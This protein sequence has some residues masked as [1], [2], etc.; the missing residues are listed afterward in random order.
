[1]CRPNFGL[2]HLK[3]AQIKQLGFYMVACSICMML[4]LSKKEE[5]VRVH[6]DRVA[7]LI[8]KNGKT[9]KW[10]ENLTQCKLRIDSKSGEITLIEGKNSKN[11]YNALNIIRA[12]GR[13]FSPENAIVLLD[14][15][16]LLD[17]LDLQDFLGKKQID[18]KKA[19]VIGTKGTVREELAKK[20]GCE[21]AIFGKTISMIG[22]PDNIEVLRKGIE[23]ILEGA[24]HK[25]VYDFLQRKSL[26]Q[27]E[28]KL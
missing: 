15:D 8:G 19:R 21:L 11:F 24:N 1:M 7:V 28:F 23:M 12:V 25:S 22:K 18:V 17:I 4:S 26:E 27:T 13:G 14:D 9:R 6:A 2:K 10:L 5:I 20:T 16:Y 3:I